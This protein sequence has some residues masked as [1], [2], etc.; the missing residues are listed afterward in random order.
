M[1][2][3]AGLIHDDRKVST[4][5]HS[6]GV[7]A[8]L[9]GGEC[10][11]EV[12]CALLNLPFARTLV[13]V[14]V[15]TFDTPTI[16]DVL[17]SETAQAVRS[18]VIFLQPNQTTTCTVAESAAVEDMGH[19]TRMDRI[20]RLTPE[21]CHSLTLVYQPPDQAGFYHGSEPWAEEYYKHN[22]LRH[23]SEL[24]QGIFD[25]CDDIGYNPLVT[26]VLSDY[27][28]IFTVVVPDG[29]FT[30]EAAQYF[31]DQV[32][33]NRKQY[34]AKKMPV[35]RILSMSQFMDR[36]EYDRVMTDKERAM[37]RQRATLLHYELSISEI[38]RCID[39]SKAR[40]QHFAP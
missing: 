9:M 24:V 8:W 39:R 6:L 27:L 18:V 5:Q 2:C 19:A 10:K 38:R 1:F 33:L 22:L 28:E 40:K 21:N 12:L 14:E 17:P 11:E 7:S 13:I 25:L 15:G 32:T 4:S 35:V 3:E 26:D 29:V 23:A 20:A 30:S 37:W 36:E 34:G 31:E 16:D